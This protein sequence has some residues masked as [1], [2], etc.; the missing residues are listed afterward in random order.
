[1]IGTS[2]TVEDAA[3]LA[4]LALETMWVLHD[5]PARRVCA[6]ILERQAD[7]VVAANSVAGVA[8]QV[9]TAGTE[10]ARS[11]TPARAPALPA[12]ERVARH[13]A[14]HLHADTQLGELAQQLGYS[15]S[16]TSALIVRVTGRTF[17]ALRAE[18]QFDRVCALL[19]Q[20]H[21][22]KDAARAVGFHDAAYLGRIFRR[23]FGMTPGAWR[24]DHAPDVAPS[25]S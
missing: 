17:V 19:R 21:S 14:T 25:I 12:S 23:R 6:E 24:R 22:V 13:L 5:D 20:G 10:L 7:A 4:C 11:L 1:M 8:A 15:S 18:L 16:H 9:R 2:A 3:R